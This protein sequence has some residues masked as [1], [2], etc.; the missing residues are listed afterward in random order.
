MD[1]ALGV[2]GEGISQESNSSLEDSLRREMAP[3]RQGHAIHFCLS[4]LTHRS[5]VNVDGID[6]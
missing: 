5:S 2:W 6:R 4:C 1:G 3:L